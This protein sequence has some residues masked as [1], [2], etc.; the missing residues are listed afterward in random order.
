MPPKA[1]AEAHGSDLERRVA[2]P[3]TASLFDHGETECF[4]GLKV[5]GK[6]ELGRGTTG[7][8][9]AFST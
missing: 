1:T 2:P 8:S 7:R 4:G 5:D 6:L 9:A 3:P